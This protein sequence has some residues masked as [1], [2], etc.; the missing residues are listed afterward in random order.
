MTDL[1]AIAS[2][3]EAFGEV[4]DLLRCEH[5]AQIPDLDAATVV[6]CAETLLHAAERAR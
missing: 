6:L 5:G 4:L 3:T 2:M 1:I